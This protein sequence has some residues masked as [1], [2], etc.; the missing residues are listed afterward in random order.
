MKELGLPGDVFP[1]YAAGA[2]NL[3][4]QPASLPRSPK[5]PTLL[6]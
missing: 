4:W 1:Y 6:P 2:H 3:L 5:E